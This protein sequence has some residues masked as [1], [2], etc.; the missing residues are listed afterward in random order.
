M[1]LTLKLLTKV[2]FSIF[3]CFYYW[4]KK[5]TKI[6]LHE[7][8]GHQAKQR[9]FLFCFR[10]P[11]NR[12]IRS[13]N[14]FYRFIDEKCFWA[15]FSVCQRLTTYRLIVINADSCPFLVPWYLYVLLETKIE[16]RLIWTDTKTHQ[17]FLHFIHFGDLSWSFAK[18]KI[19]SAN[20][21][22]IK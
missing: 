9:R 19:I 20:L 6:E 7:R 21:S 3:F 15:N 5:K 16:S 18:K 11:S 22:I 12:I 1:N 14:Y 4:M 10:K 8:T 13:K 17:F 2:F